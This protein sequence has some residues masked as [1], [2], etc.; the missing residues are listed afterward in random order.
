ML[1]RFNCQTYNIN[2]PSFNQR[3]IFWIE[4]PKEELYKKI[5]H[6]K[7]VCYDPSQI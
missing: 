4:K 3:L 1:N 5:R 2:Q 7:S 6:M